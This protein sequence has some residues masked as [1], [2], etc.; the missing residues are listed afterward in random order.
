MIA[1]AELDAAVF[2]DAGAP[3]LRT[4]GRREFFKA[5]HAMR[6]AMHGLVGDVGSQIVEQ[7]HRG[8]ELRE[9]MLDRQNLPPI[10]QRALRQ[11]PDLGETVEHHPA[12]PRPFYGFKDLLGGF[13]Q[14]EIRRIQQALLL[15]GIEEAFRGQQF[16]DL[17]VLAQSPA[18]GGCAV[19]QLVFGFG[20][21]D[22]ET[23][24]TGPRALQQ[25]LQRYGGF[26]G[27]GRAFHQKQVSARKSARQD[28]VQSPNA[29]LRLAGHRFN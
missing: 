16:E 7:H 17:D 27:P 1:A 26:A 22:V 29:G 21:S 10:A 24:L 12:G 6:D 14:F 25:K 11:K 8:G 15:L 2:D 28:I 5:Q 9:V 23:L 3:P 13:A 20:Q 18:M 4:I 19:A